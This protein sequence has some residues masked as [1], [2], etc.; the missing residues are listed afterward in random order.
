LVSVLLAGL[1]P[2]V[3]A[4]AGEKDDAKTTWVGMPRAEIVKLLG[5]PDKLKKDDDG[6][7]VLVYKMVRVASGAYPGPDLLLVDVPDVG[8]IGRPLDR[9]PGAPLGE[10]PI[11]STMTDGEGRPVDTPGSSDQ[12]HSTSR[13][14]KTGEVETW[15]EDLP[16]GR[17]VLGKLTLRLRVGSDGRI[18]EVIVP[19]KHRESPQGSD[20]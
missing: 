17:A 1:L 6:N 4:L 3:L 14:L 20:D 10:I 16:K 15:P 13:N 19:K 8:L 9:R 18:T 11:P 12:R 2:T 7:A 5:E